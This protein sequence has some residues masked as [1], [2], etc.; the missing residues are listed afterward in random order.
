QLLQ[1]LPQAYSAPPLTPTFAGGP[2]PVNLPPVF[3]PTPAA[4]ISTG[5]AY[6]APPELMASDVAPTAPTAPQDLAFIN[7]YAGGAPTPP[8]AP[9]RLERIAGI[10]GGVSAGLQGRAPEYLDYLRQPQREY[11]AQ[12]ERYQG[13]RAQGIQLEERRRERQQEM[14]TREAQIKSER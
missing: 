8:R 5:P 6:G 2:P 14:A 13:R 12:L 1:L 3:A 9:S 4:P 11:Q 7:A 10:L